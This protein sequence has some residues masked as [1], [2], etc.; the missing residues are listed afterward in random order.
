M[1]ICN[2]N[3]KFK[4]VYNISEDYLLNIIEG[5][6]KTYFDWAFLNIGAWFDATI[7]SQSIYGTNSHAKLLYFEDEAYDPGSVW[8][9]IRKDWVWES[10]VNFNESNPIAIS[11]LYINDSFYP[12][13]PGPG[14]FEI[15]YPNGRILLDNPIN[16]ESNVEL[17]YSYRFVQTYRAIDSPWFSLLQYS[18]LQTDNKD[19]VRNSDG[20]WSIGPNHRFQLPAII[21]EAVARSRSRP[22]EIGSNSLIIE[23]D[24]TF[25]ILA[26]N[27]SDR[28]KLLDI[29]RLQ[30]DSVIWLYNTNTLAQDDKYPLD[31]N[32]NL[33]NN[34][35][36]Y[37]NIIDQYK[38]RKCW[39]KNVNLFEIDSFHPNM[40]RGM[41]R[42][43]LEIISE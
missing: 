4:Q 10:G 1:S 43:T 6:F 20:D 32:G 23:Q 27:K 8:Q 11:G 24:I 29:L 26:E 14:A 9:G 40:H 25:H 21:I 16:A 28:N 12:N 18:S 7:D 15:D 2:D 41:I 39:I 31:H 38:W 42:A 37:P 35:L 17:N 3:T 19:I 33:K 36:M 13:I 5:N 22:F 34:P 30:Q